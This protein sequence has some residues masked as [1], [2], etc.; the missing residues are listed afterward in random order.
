MTVAA[1][2]VGLV[3]SIVTISSAT[4]ALQAMDSK[5][6]LGRQK[7]E[8]LSAYLQLKQVPQYLTDRIIEFIEYHTTATK[9]VMGLHE[10]SELPYKLQ[11]MLAMQLHRGL[12]TNCPIFQTLP[13]RAVLSLLRRLKPAVYPPATILIQEG[14]PNQRLY[15]VSEGVVNVW[16]SF[17]VR[18]RG[19]GSRGAGSRDVD[20][21][22]RRQCLEE[23]RGD[24]A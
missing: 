4:T 23:R 16:K 24:L 13:E 18:P 21:V 10:L 12:I 9:T 19:A 3:T 1:M 2:F 8:T 7:L 22:G 6:A 14:M 15:F 17:E 5:K 11:M 20:P